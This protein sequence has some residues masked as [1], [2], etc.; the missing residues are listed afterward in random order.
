MPYHSDDF[1]E[2]VLIQNWFDVH[3]LEHLR[4]YRYLQRTGHWEEGFLPDH[5]I[6]DA[7]TNWQVVLM[8]RMADA[9]ITQHC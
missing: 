8:S 5:V 9:W 6:C 3:S 1:Q 2:R 4:A 7:S